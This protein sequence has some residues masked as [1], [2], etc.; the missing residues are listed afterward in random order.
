MC[1]SLLAV[2]LAALV[3]VRIYE[4]IPH[5]EDE[6]AYVWQARLIA[7]GDLSTASPEF[8]KSFLV[9]F[10]VDH[11]G[12]RFGKYPLG[13]PALLGVGEWLG[14]RDW[15]N[16]FLAGLAVWLIYRL[17]MRVFNE[18]VGLIA[19]LL[20]VVSPF[21]LLNAGSLLAHVWGLV[22]TC[23]FALFWLDVF[24]TAHEPSQEPS[25]RLWLKTIAAA[26]VMGVLVLS[27]P[28]TALG[29]AL[30]FAFHGL[31][32]LVRADNQVRLRLLVFGVVCV[33]LASLHFLWQF[34]VTGSPWTNP[35][36]LW[37]EYDSV[38]FGPGHGV[39]PQGHTLRQARTNTRF[40]LLVGYSDLF[41]WARYSWIFIPFGVWA[42][43]RRARR[44]W[45]AWLVA[46]IFPALL[47]FYMAYWVGSWL[48]G[49]RYYFEGLASLVLLSAVGI[50]WLAGWPIQPGSHLHASESAPPRV[51]W[52]KLRPLAVTALLA[53]L[54]SINL[55]FYLPPRLQMM[56]S[57]YTISRERLEPFQSMQAQQL[58]P[59]LVIVH[60]PRWMAYGALLELE[61]SYLT[62]PFIFAYSIGP[63]TDAALADS[64]PDRNIIH[65]YPDDPWKFYSAPLPR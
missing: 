3:S 18:G 43:L 47:L 26:L 9:P 54:V 34:D 27:R 41:G 4:R 38:G 37:W 25:K 59:A 12:R 58:T 10:V 33:L 35:Y 49:P 36:T 15:I 52:R 42:V 30:P 53:F 11:E 32:L 29:V 13:W 44:F 23:A 31:F 14:L 63:Q 40:S 65:Y 16:P 28:Y 56:Q 6:I 57:L 50:V 61:D 48:F 20:T 8:S 60:T 2:A 62:S 51:G 5:L 46:G 17:G 55:V 19:A 45:R 24:G 22:L 1:F 21:F 7:G 64:Y 39:S